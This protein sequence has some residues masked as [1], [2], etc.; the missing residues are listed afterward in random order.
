MERHQIMWELKNYSS[1]VP[2]AEVDKFLRDLKENPQVSVGVMISRTTDIYGKHL[3][4]PLLVEFD[5]DKMMI[6]IS[7]FETFCGED[8]GRVFQMLTALFRIWW[9]Y[10]KEENQVFDRTRERTG[11]SNGG[12]GKTANGVASP[13]GAS[14]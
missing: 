5:G 7:Q 3:T 6:Y 13:Q 1:V 4:G 8:E 11:K 9:E 10:H 14:G 2:K 12:A